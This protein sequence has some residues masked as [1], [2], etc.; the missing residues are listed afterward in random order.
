MLSRGLCAMYPSWS[1]PLQL[2]AMALVTSP[3]AP[4]CELPQ[5]CLPCL[6]PVLQLRRILSGSTPALR[7]SSLFS[8][9]SRSTR[10]RASDTQLFVGPSLTIDNKLL[11]WLSGS[12]QDTPLCKAQQRTQAANQ[13]RPAQQ[14]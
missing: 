9:L 14:S 1:Q 4:G 12:Y 6:Q 7:F 8:S 11:S 5:H 10:D 13:P 3:E 2:E